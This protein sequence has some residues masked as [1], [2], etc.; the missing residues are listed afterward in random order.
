L[1][2]L[3]EE[4]RAALW[5]V[6]N[7]RWLALAVAWGFCLLGWLG[8]AFIPNSYESK[9]RMFVQLDDMLADQIGIGSDARK[10]DLERMRQTLVSATNLEKIIRS[11]KIGETVTSPGQME[12]AVAS[13]GED[14]KLVGDE[15]NVFTLTVTSGRSNMSDGENAQLAQDVAL[16]LIDIARETNLGGSRGEMRDTIEFLDQQLAQRQAQL[17]QAEQRRLAFEAEHPEMIGGAVG[18]S[19]QLANNR[20][21]LRSVEADLA[22]GQSALAAIEGQLAGTPRSLVTAGAGGPRA[23]LAQAEANLA[24]LQARGL[25]D[26]HPDVVA[27][28]RQI[29]SLRPLANGP[30]AD[31]GG[32]ANPAWQS[33]QAMKVERQSNVQAL[34]SRAAALRAE[35]AQVTASQASEPA[36]AAEAQR[37]SRDYE[38]LRKQY[39]ELLADREEL[40]LR[41]QVETERSSVK[42]DVVDPPSTPRVPSFPNRPLFLFGILVLGVG[43]GSATAFALGKFNGTFATASKLERTFELPVIGS[44]SHTLN[45]AAQSLRKRKLK[46]FALATGGLGALFVVLL[47]VEFIQRG[48]VA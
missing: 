29:A 46:Q 25:T 31:A 35:L 37:I 47:G 24:A 41:G 15:K 45:A 39:D 14:I 9:A 34:Q 36:A 21:E 27:L 16:K 17:E 48:M 13:L 40:R 38:V 11:T 43:A 2:L 22:A 5:S 3:I 19:T 44:I 42:F 8:L 6:W 1:N 32:T 20:A 4:L 18:I 30:N 33:L 10:Q 7:R 28:K 26:T 23:A 12:R